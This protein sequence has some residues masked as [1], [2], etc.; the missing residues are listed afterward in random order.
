MTEVDLAALSRSEFSR[1]VALIARR[2]GAHRVDLA[3]DA[4]QDAFAAAVRTWGAESPPRD[5]RAWLYR[6]AWNR[7][8]D[9]LRR[10]EA[11]S[12]PDEE[13]AVGSVAVPDSRIGP[14]DS[15]LRL[16]LLC[17]HPVL[18]AESQVALTLKV[19]AGFSVP[20]IGRLL[21]ASPDAVDQRLVR[22]KRSL[23]RLGA[24][25]ELSADEIRRRAAVALT[26]LYAMF[27]EGYASITAPSGLRRE[28][29]FEALRLARVMLADPTTWSPEAHAVAALFAFQA[30][31]LD[32][33]VDDAGE[34]QSIRDQ[35]RSRWNRQLIAL[36]TDHLR[37]A[38]AGSNLSRYHLEA[39]IAA[40]HA[41]A[42]RYE[43]TD[44]G[45]IT[46]L[47]DLLA[48]R[49]PTPLVL[50]NRAIALGERDGPDAALGALTE[51]QR[52][53][54]GDPHFHAAWADAAT[55]LGRLN[56][57]RAH[58]GRAAA[59]ATAPASKRLLEIR[60]RQLDVGFGPVRPS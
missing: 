28:L 10:A 43:A 45:R 33:R 35:D 8:V 44:W 31:R 18:S 49:S 54:E 48:A 27:S 56:E 36:G 29:C 41:A 32:T 47:Y 7:A 21:R 38:A 37:L 19:A 14:N 60:L 23:L 57:A 24:D 39:E 55:R 16:I 34:F 17:C 40:C 1:L 42:P 52:E 26:V 12:L 5:A 2:I 58:L 13:L 15:E 53:L 20:E 3:E 25:F 4:V 6:S 22:A 9:R 30:S 51:L 50:L 59:G 46:D 11:A